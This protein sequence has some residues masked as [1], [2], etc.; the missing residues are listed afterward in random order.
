MNLTD[1]R[2]EIESIQ[3]MHEQVQARGRLPLAEAEA[4]VRSLSM[5]MPSS[6]WIPLTA[7]ASIS[8]RSI[9][10]SNGLTAPFTTP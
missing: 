7:S 10:A 4:V 9:S 5:A 2:E 8:S 6:S 3:S 1:L